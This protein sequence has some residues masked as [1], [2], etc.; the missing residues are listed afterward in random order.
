MPRDPS[1]DIEITTVECRVLNGNFPWNLVTVETDAGVRGYGEAFNGPISEHIEYLE[2]A[3]VGE[4]PYDVERLTEHMTQTLSGLGGGEGYSQ[5]AVAGIET[6]LWDAVGKLTGLPVYQLLGGKFQDS[7]DIYCDCHAGEYLNVG[8]DDPHETYDPDVY[9]DIAEEVVGEGFV[10]LKFGLDVA[11]GDADTATRR[12]TNAAVQHKV[13]IVDAIRERI[14]M[15][16]TLAFDLHEKLEPVF[17]AER[18][19]RQ[20]GLLGKVKRLFLGL[21]GQ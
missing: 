6:A 9:A 17:D 4:N 5:A 15:E 8:D 21:R 19:R 2:P 1:R 18:E 10:A 7:V 11:A 16:P 20:I 12:L 13:D 3:L 14:G